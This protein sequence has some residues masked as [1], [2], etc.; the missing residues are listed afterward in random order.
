[1]VTNFTGEFT[2]KGSWFGN[3]I[4]GGTASLSLDILN[5]IDGAH[6]SM[7]Q[8]ARDT[9]NGAITCAAGGVLG[10]N[11]MTPI[12]NCLNAGE[13][14][15]ILGIMYGVYTLGEDISSVMMSAIKCGD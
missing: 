9:M 14:N 15:V 11:N 8:M 10:Q 6:N 2:S 13:A 1:M 3:S 12:D 5:N 7:G 4:G